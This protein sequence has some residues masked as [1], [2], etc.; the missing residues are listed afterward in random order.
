MAGVISLFFQSAG[1]RLVVCDLHRA[2]LMFEIFSE[3]YE[4]MLYG[5]L[6]LVT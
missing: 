4:L 2:S 6:C 3:R 1:L 5:Q